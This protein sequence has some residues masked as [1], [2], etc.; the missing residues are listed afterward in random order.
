MVSCPVGWISAVF[1]SAPQEGAC[2]HL[3]SEL[4]SA[5]TPKASVAGTL[6]RLGTERTTVISKPNK[7]VDF[8]LDPRNT[9]DQ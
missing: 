1:T 8:R 3:T 2:G 6:C 7:G 5:S 9:I 4:T